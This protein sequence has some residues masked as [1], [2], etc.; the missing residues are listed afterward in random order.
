MGKLIERGKNLSPMHIDKV[1][2]VNSCILTDL[3]TITYAN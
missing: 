1:D 2:Y 3:T